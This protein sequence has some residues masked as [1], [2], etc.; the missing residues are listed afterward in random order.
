MRSLLFVLLLTQ[1]SAL[2]AEVDD[3]NMA[4]INSWSE[5]KE[6]VTSECGGYKTFINRSTQECIFTENGN[7][8]YTKFYS[9]AAN[10]DG[11]KYNIRIVEYQTGASAVIAVH[12]GSVLKLTINGVEKNGTSFTS[13]ARED[14]VAEL[15]ARYKNGVPQ[16]IKKIPKFSS[17]ENATE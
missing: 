12:N 6:L 13:V 5:A 3:S 15:V 8:V 2:S 9:T 11:E 14:G 7:V 4:V 10:A 16:E 17:L 1:V